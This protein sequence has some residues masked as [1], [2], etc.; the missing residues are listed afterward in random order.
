MVSQSVSGSEAEL[1][2]ELEEKEVVYFG[3][4]EV[5]NFLG[6]ERRNAYQLLNRMKR[7][8]LVV[9]VER[10]K[11]VLKELWNSLDVY[12][13]ASELVNA[14]YIGFWSALHFHGLTDQVPRKVFVATPK[15][16]ESLEIQGDEV[17]FVNI[18]KSMMFGYEREGG[19]RVSNPEKTVVDSLRFPSKAGGIDHVYRCLKNDLEVE[20]I[21]DYCL[22]M[23]VDTVIA[24]AGYLLD[25]KGFDGLERLK[26]EVEELDQ[27]AVLSP[28][29]GRTNL[30]KEWKIYVNVNLDD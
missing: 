20:K 23:G 18:Q 13:L 10:G 11:Y 1:I 7:K 5:S 6:I 25:R 15:R 22:R 9:H 14:S 29:S 30:D 28:G 12:R 21:T 3:P 17:R 8:G 2:E 24:R 4:R 16:K 27:R 19:V 26:E